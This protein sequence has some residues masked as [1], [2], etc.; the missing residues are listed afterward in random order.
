V[1]ELQRL[2]REGKYNEASQLQD[3]LFELHNALFIEPNP[4]G[5]KYAVSLLGL[6]TDECRLPM[7]PLQD[8][9]KATI[10]RVMEELELI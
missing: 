6:C 4:A 2:C 1:V 3:K 8:S 10:R 9:T 7:V 5:P